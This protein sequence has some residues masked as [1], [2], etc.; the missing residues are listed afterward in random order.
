M[1]SYQVNCF[2]F[3]ILGALLFS[4]GL[5]QN[6]RQISGFVLTETGSPVYNAKVLNGGTHVHTGRQG[7]FVLTGVLT[8]DSLIVEHLYYKNKIYVVL[9]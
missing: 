4:N 3:T 8:G 2:I 5:G 1:N 9:A 7:E 6:A